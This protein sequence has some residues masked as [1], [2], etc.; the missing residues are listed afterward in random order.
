MRSTLA[1]LAFAAACT[2][3]AVIG[4]KATTPEIPHWYARIRK[5]SWTPPRLAFPIVWPILYA[6]IAIAGWRLWEA[7]PSDLRM[8]ALIAF[9][10]QLA[11]N[12]AWSP[13]FF[14]AHRILA[15]LFVILLLDAAI[16]ATIWMSWDVDRW[17]SVLLL[18]YLAWT[19][20]ATALNAK[21]WTLNRN[22]IAV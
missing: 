14:A 5:P 15:G 20:F 4:A 12:A 7:P 1:F 17:T 16:S 9:A 22:A 18:P 2:M 11:L 21:I 19:I 13:V 8:A 3:I 10:I 6:M